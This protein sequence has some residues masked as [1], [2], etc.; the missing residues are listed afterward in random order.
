MTEDVVRSDRPHD[1]LTHLCAQMTAILDT[2]E[3]SDVKAIV[4]LSAGS[5]GGLQTHGYDDDTEATVDLF[6][7]LAAL[8]KGSGKELHLMNE[9]GVIVL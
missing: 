2:E 7:H 3:N 8:F 6:V 9:D 1:R 4:M 5:K